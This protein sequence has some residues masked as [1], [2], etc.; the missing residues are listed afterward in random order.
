MHALTQT[1]RPVLVVDED[2]LVGELVG[3]RIA[4]EGYDVVYT[5]DVDVA[6][7]TCVVG[8]P[9]MLVIDLIEDSEDG[10]ALLRRLDRLE[11]GPRVIVLR[12]EPGPFGAFSRLH[13]TVLGGETWFDDLPGLVKQLAPREGADLEGLHEQADRGRDHEERQEAL[14]EA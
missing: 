10:A 5:N 2:T 9:G 11:D 6:Y 1:D 8:R 4:A 13:V 12:Y 7:L 3:R 14:S